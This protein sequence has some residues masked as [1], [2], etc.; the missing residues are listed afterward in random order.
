MIL[1]PE[2]D[3]SIVGELGA[4]LETPTWMQELM[5]LG[6]PQLPP[7]AIRSPMLPSYISRNIDWKC[8]TWDMNWLPC[9]DGSL[10]HC[11][12]L[13]ALEGMLIHLLL[14]LWAISR[15]LK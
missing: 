11:T 9:A 15:D 2:L 5:N 12:T 7:Q 6:H 14:V 10:T 8:D 4:S 1:S 13:L 3:C